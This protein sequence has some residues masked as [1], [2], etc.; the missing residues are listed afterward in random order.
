LGKKFGKISMKS[1][2]EYP[3]EEL[4]LIYHLLH[5]QIPQ[6]TQL[7][8]SDLLQDLQDYLLQQAKNEGVDVAVHKQWNSWLQPSEQ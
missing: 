7:I 8:G 1:L 6:H 3:V 5:T 4:K 2:A